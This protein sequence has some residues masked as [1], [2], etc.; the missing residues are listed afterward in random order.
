MSKIE[1]SQD[2]N[3]ICNVTGGVDYDS[4]PYTVTFPAG[5]TSVSFDVAINDDNILENNETFNLTIMT[6]SLSGLV[7]QHSFIQTKVLILDNDR[8]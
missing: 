4:G 2:I 3:S 8:E 5:V 7:S 6:S 1:L